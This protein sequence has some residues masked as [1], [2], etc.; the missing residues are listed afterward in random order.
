MIES[1][2]GCLNLIHLFSIRDE[3]WVETQLNT[4][5]DWVYELPYETELF[6][7]S[8]IANSK[9]Y[10]YKVAKSYWCVFINLL[11]AYTLLA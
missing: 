2:I 10:I 11:M 5:V 1:A 8:Y 6:E 4:N 9:F 7:S 3:I